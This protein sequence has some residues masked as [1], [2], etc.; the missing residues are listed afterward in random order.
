[1]QSTSTTKRVGYGTLLR[2]CPPPTQF[3][4]LG[5]RPCMLLWIYLGAK[6]NQRSCPGH[7]GVASMGQHQAGQ[8]EQKNVS[9]T[10]SGFSDCVGGVR[11]YVLR[12][13]SPSTGK[14][15]GRGVIVVQ[16]A[17]CL[18]DRGTNT[19]EFWTD[20]FPSQSCLFCFFVRRPCSACPA[21]RPSNNQ[22]VGKAGCQC[23]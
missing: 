21:V 8:E 20:V 9:T 14:N 22:T 17:A 10:D 3:K 12:N 6:P 16:T 11:R 19:E 23:V 18:N 2:T 7:G 5:P 15:T 13:P 1:M 4:A